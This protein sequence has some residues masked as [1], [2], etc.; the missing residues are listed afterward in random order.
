[1]LPILLTL[2]GILLVLIAVVLIVASTKP[3]EFSIQRSQMMSAPPSAPF[4][5][6][7]DFKNWSAWSPWE[8]LDPN[9][10]HIFEGPPMG[11]G[12]SHSWSGNNKAGEGKATITDSRPHESIRMRLEFVRP[13]KATNEVVFLF[14]PTGQQTNVT[15]LM[16]GKNNFMGKI[17]CV[18]MN[19][20]KMVGT[21]F[22]KGLSAMKSIVET[23]VK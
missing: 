11:V 23:Q 14:Q 10:R 18:F 4:A 15:W 12:S 9:M 3:A 6:V 17:V 22:E 1:M 5:Q 13:F 19:M 20:D 21:D 16:N 2:L 7:N 8:K